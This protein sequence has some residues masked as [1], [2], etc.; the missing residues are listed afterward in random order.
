[1][2]NQALS[3][4]FTFP[5][6]V[7]YEDTDAGGVVFYANYLKFFERARTEWLRFL[8]VNQSNLVGS[9]RVIFVVVGK[10]KVFGQHPVRVFEMDTEWMEAGKA[11]YLEDLAAAK[12][13]EE[14]GPSLHIETIHRPRW[15]K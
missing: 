3:K 11:A 9:D 15:A 1:M 10:R 7:Y 12:E 2:T 6:R 14:F 5:V 13:L 8:G 4:E